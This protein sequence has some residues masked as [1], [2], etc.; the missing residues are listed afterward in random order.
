MTDAFLVLNRFEYFFI[1]NNG[2]NLFFYKIT[3]ICT[4][5]EEWSLSSKDTSLPKR[6]HGVGWQGAKSRMFVYVLRSLNHDRFYVGM[7]EDVERRL[8]EHNKGKTKSTKG[9]RPW[10]MFFFESYP[11]RKTAREREKY[12]KSGIGRNWVR[13]KWSLS[14]TG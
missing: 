6:R 8:V 13:K 9:Y 2:L 1:K 4:P 12:L 3:Y 5:L 7:T 14:S 11:D 10:A